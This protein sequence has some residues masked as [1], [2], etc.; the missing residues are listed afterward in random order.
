MIKDD[1]FNDFDEETQKLFEEIE[2]D[3]AIKQEKI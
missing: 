2:I 3:E 1:L